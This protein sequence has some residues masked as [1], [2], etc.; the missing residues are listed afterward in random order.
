MALELTLGQILEALLSLP[1]LKQSAIAKASY[2]LV[3]N[4]TV[5]SGMT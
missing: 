3:K 1:L 5:L 2:G 4:K